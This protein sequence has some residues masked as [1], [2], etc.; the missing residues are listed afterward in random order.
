MHKKQNA[1]KCNST[2]ENAGKPCKTGLY[3]RKNDLSDFPL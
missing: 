1:K 2:K 3:F